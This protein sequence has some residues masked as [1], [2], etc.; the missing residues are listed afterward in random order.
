MSLQQHATDKA[1]PLASRLKSIGPLLP[2]FIYAFV[3]LYLE[4]IHAGDSQAATPAG[5]EA[6]HIDVAPGL[7]SFGLGIYFFA[8]LLSLLLGRSGLS[9]RERCWFLAIF[10][11]V[12]STLTVVGYDY[13]V[14]PYEQPKAAILLDD[15]ALVCN[16]TRIPWASIAGLEEYSALDN[17]RGSILGWAIVTPAAAPA[18]K[19]WCRITPMIEP[20]HAVY[21]AIERRWLAHRS[22]G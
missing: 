12:F 11:P 6:F 16:G 10:V 21:T 1:S 17:R 2:I 3:C 18:A 14:L 22:P 13:G 4:E 5:A 7:L 15:A 9:V 8:W 19:T 20:S